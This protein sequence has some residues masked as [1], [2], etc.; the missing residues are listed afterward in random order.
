MIEPLIMIG[1]LFYFFTKS[2]CPKPKEK[3][4]PEEEFGK[5]VTKYLKTGVL[6]RIKKEDG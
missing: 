3:P 4:D 2:F 5:A 1:V 6:V